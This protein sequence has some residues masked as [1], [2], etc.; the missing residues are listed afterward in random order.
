MNTIVALLLILIYLVFPTPIFPCSINLDTLTELPSPINLDAICTKV[1]PTI[2]YAMLL[3]DESGF[4][5]GDVVEVIQDVD[6]GKHYKVKTDTLCTWI[7]GCN[8]KFLDDPYTT[9]TPPP[10][11]PIEL[12]AYINAYDNTSDTP[13]FVWVDLA[14]QTVYIFNGSN[15]N[16]ELCKFLICSTG[17]QTTSTIRGLFQVCDKGLELKTHERAKYWVKFHENYL[18]HSLPIDEQGNVID[19]RLGIPLSNGCIRMHE[20]DAKWFFDT[21]PVGTTV[22][23]N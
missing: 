2:I 9:A 21:V 23:I 17:K 7:H 20:D 5:K 18:F 16:W 22:W 15:K 11:Y 13:Y 10:I 14:R 8:I 4:K 6:N 12:E 3:C 19:T 1:R